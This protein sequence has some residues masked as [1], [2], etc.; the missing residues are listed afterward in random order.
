MK[1]VL[2]T[3]IE[4]GKFNHGYLLV[5]DFETSRKM[6]RTAAT[7]I[8]KSD[9]NGIDI[10]SRLE[11]HPDFFY[12]KYDL[13]GVEEGRDLIKKAGQRPFVGENKVF[14]VELFS[15]SIE[16]ANALLKTMEE[17]CEG[18]YFFILV[19][20]LENVLPT[21]ISRLTIIDNSGIKKELDDKKLKFYTKFLADKPNKRLEA[22]KDIKER[23]EAIEFLN[24]IEL[25]L[26]SPTSKCAWK[27]NFQVLEEIQ[28]C[29][30]FLFSQG[31]SA[32]MVLEHI[33][34]VLPAML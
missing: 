1:S 31:A 3:H 16:S 26:G 18:T 17:P 32:K 5:G 22:I 25:L 23:Q 19:P 14:I 28:K 15:F 33:A 9:I 10:V 24:E 27:S 34:L 20:S 30:S 2:E 8:L 12:E 21:L 13:F 7:V 11:S 29:K 6:A 4:S